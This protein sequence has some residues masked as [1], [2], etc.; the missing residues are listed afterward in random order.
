MLISTPSFDPQ[1]TA[2]DFSL[3]D[4][5]SGDTINKSEYVA[6]RPYV[7]A[8]ICNHCPYVQGIITEFVAIAKNLQE[9]GVA[10][11]AV[12]SND[13]SFV[14][15]DSPEHMREFAQM[16]NFTFPYLV[17]ENQ[18]VAHN[19]G[20]VCTPDFFGFASDHTM[21]FRG[22]INELEEAMIQIKESGTTEISQHPSKGCSIKWK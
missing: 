10:V 11:I 17:D 19:F 16:N 6:D 20:A 5:I 8:F 14:E 1:F 12:M 22:R 18:S 3:T 2:P 13:Y 9:Q 4:V 21:Q 7:I 15:M